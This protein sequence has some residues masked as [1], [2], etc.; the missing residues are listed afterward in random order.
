MT[1]V[2]VNQRWFHL[3]EKKIK[4]YLKARRIELFAMGVN[5]KVRN[6]KRGLAMQEDP[7]A[8]QIGLMNRELKRFQDVC[9]IKDEELFKL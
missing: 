2:L 5:Q 7:F 1:K 6:M 4:Q 9:G 3:D 8:M